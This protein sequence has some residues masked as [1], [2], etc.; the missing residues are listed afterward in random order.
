MRRVLLEVSEQLDDEFVVWIQ[1]L[2]ADDR[3]AE[4]ALELFL[5]GTDGTLSL[6]A[7]EIGLLAPMVMGSHT[8]RAL[9]KVIPVA[10][11]R[12]IP[13]RF[14]IPIAESLC[15][16]S[17]SL[18]DAAALLVVA[19]TP[20]ALSLRVGCRL[21]AS[22]DLPQAWHYVIE[23]A[24]AT[25][26]RSLMRVTEEV[27]LAVEAVPH[28][29]FMVDSYASNDMLPPYFRDLVKLGRIIWCR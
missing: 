15:T 23:F 6:Q 22:D 24:P 1:G 5:A 13:L 10:T 11:S 7:K 2:L 8:G 9:L 21:A 14:A 29:L 18:M 20:G 25:H 12:P 16:I 26:P 28:R 4:A 27:R 19:N 17:D 3:V